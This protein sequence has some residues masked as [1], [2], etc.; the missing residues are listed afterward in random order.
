MIGNAR[1]VGN[2]TRFPTS[3]DVFQ[4]VR[5]CAPKGSGFSPFAGQRSKPGCGP[6]ACDVVAQITDLCV[7]ADWQLGLALIQSLQ[8]RCGGLLDDP[9]PDAAPVMTATGRLAWAGYERFLAL[10][11]DLWMVV[12][13]AAPGPP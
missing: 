6:R 7:R 2:Q 9:G 8:E 4:G 10:T 1:L 3:P 5:R 12:S 13:S 11:R